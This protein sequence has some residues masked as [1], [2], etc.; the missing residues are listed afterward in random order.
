MKILNKMLIVTI[1]VVFTACNDKEEFQNGAIKKEN[2]FLKKRQI[3][4]NMNET[5]QEAMIQKINLKLEEEKNK[6]NELEKKLLEAQYKFNIKHKREIEKEI[7]DKY[8][9]YG[10][11]F[12]VILLILISAIV[13]LYIQKNNFQKALEKKFKEEEIET[14]EL[15]KKVNELEIENYKLVGDLKITEQNKIIEIINGYKERRLA[16]LKEIC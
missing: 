15:R 8:S 5:E 9:Y 14:K 11:S 12:I 3:E 13:I 1:L 7:T 10:I 4:L 16:E 2:E 6:N